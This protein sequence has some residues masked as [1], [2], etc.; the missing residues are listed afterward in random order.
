[1]KMPIKEALVWKM[2][3]SSVITIPSD[4]VSNGQIKVGKKYSVIIE[5]ED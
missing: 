5:V 2:G 3:N 4:Y 1:M